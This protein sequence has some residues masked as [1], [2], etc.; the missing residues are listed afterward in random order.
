MQAKSD[1]IPILTEFKESPRNLD[2]S[3]PPVKLGDLSI[4]CRI[5]Y[6]VEEDNT[7]SEWLM[8]LQSQFGYVVPA[9]I[10]IRSR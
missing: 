2:R 3:V 1:R 10:A 8:V 4:N 5:V 9:L 6:F 7:F